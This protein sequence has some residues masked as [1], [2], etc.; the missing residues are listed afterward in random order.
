[1]SDT[2]E[3]LLGRQQDYSLRLSPSRIQ[4]SRQI[5][6]RVQ[7]GFPSHSRIVSTACY[8]H[9]NTTSKVHRMRQTQLLENLRV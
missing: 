2:C 7:F 1:M 9:D 6:A 8:N 3:E 5:H 4:R